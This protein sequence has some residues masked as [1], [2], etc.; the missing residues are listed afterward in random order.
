MAKPQPDELNEYIDQAK[1]DAIFA[2]GFLRETGT[3]TASHIGFNFQH[4]IPGHEKLLTV[5]FPPPW[6]RD[7]EPKATLT[8][9]PADHI[10]SEKRLDADTV[11]HAHTPNL[12]AWSLAQKPF[13]IRYV[14]PQRHLLARE[15][16]N[17]LERRRSQLDVI[18]ERLDRYPD[19]APP[20]GL[21]ESNGGANFWGR[22]ILKTAELIL[23]IEEGAR[24]QAIAEQIGGAKEYTEGALEVQWSRTGLVEKGQS[25]ARAFAPAE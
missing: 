12:A 22:G 6:S 14:A 18:R 15:I 8:E 19:L 17:H 3:L 2:Y 24:I 9:F 5:S 7:R 25:Y 16:P 4:K 20:P 13:P 10:L 1:R 23:L 11:A 21:L